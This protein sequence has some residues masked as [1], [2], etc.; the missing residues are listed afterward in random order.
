MIH[1]ANEKYLDQIMDIKNTS[2]TSPWNRQQLLD[3][4]MSQ[5]NAENWI[6]VKKK[7]VVGYIFGWSEHHPWEGG[8]EKFVQ[9]DPIHRSPFYRLPEHVL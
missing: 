5:I 1:V 6:Y 8:V 4:L 9:G 2:F 7:R 3:D